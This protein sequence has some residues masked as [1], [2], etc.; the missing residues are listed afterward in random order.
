[1]EAFLQAFRRFI[2]RRGRPLIVYSDNETN[3]RRTANTLKKIYFS[4]LKCDPTLK[5]I[6]RKFIPPGVP[7]LGGWWERLIIICL[8]NWEIKTGD[9]IAIRF[10]TIF[11]DRK[12]E[13][14]H[15]DKGTEFVNSVTQK[16]LKN[17][18]IK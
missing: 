15:T 11:K 10:P 9:V 7:W 4:R 3:L 8:G 17:H 2:D 14:L 12:P 18:K 13:R 16:L 6:T 1:M 5:G